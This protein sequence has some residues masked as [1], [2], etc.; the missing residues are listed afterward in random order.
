[1]SYKGKT[2]KKQGEGGKKG[3]TPQRGGGSLW[4]YSPKNIYEI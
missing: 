4:N 3:K 1:M 2:N